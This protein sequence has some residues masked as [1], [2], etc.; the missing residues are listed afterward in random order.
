M[1]DR[2]GRGKR[3]SYNAES[4]TKDGRATGDIFGA[5]LLS[6]RYGTEVDVG[7]LD[8]RKIWIGLGGLVVRFV[9]ASSI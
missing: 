3:K 9:S 8:S 7:G 6:I 4:V 2:K 1:H 5:E